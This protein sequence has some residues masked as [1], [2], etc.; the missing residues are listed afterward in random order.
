MKINIIFQFLTFSTIFSEKIKRI[1]NN[2]KSEIHLVIKGEGNQPL[3]S[4]TKHPEVWVNGIYRPKCNKSCDLSGY[5]SKVILKFEEKITSLISFFYDLENITEVDL[6]RF[7]ASL[8]TSLKSMFERCFNLEIVTFGN[9]NFTIVEDMSHTFTSCKKLI[10]IDLSNFDT[11]RV[12]EMKG[13]FG[14][15]NS[16]IYL[17]LKKFK[18]TDTVPFDFAFNW[19]PSNAK[20]CIEDTTAKDKLTDWDII[21]DCSH[22]CFQENIKVDL[23][24]KDC[25]ENCKSSGY[26]YEYNNICYNECPNGTYSIFCDSI[27]CN[28]NVKECFILPEGYYLDSEEQNYKKCFEKCKSCFGPGNATNNN[29]SECQQG[30]IFLN[31]TLFQTNCYQKCQYYYYFEEGS[32]YNCTE[33]DKC[34]EK[35]NKLILEKNK[36]IDECKKD[37]I[38]RYEYNNICYS[39]CPN[40]TINDE[41]N[42]ICY[43]KS[44]YSTI[45]DNDHMYSDINNIFFIVQE[46]LDNYIINNTN[47]SN[48]MIQDEI[49]EY[50]QEILI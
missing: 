27:E 35:Y 25:T 12:K 42:Y 50:I 19:V 16:L 23:I 34:P 29:C 24:R 47:I 17:N 22:K 6:S 8:V 2:N 37:E 36:C 49:L 26:E 48:I 33:D 46:K 31:E 32:N 40:G 11:S 38:Y 9:A 3:M 5:K 39:K 13:I 18:F 20:Y 7:D 15:C 41:N 45:M 1:L 10:Y 28:E 30:L 14:I 4:G 21:P 43:N 44:I